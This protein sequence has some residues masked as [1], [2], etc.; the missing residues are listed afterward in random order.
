[1]MKCAPVRAG[2]NEL[3]G[4]GLAYDALGC[5]DP[6]L[7]RNLA[8]LITTIAATRCTAIPNPSDAMLNQKPYRSGSAPHSLS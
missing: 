1:M 2:F 3:F 4:G 8:I 6:L 7:P 5:A